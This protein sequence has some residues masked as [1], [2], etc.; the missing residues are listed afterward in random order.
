MF[1]GCST[2]QT[3]TDLPATTL[4]ESCY[5]NMFGGCSDMVVYLS[6]QSVYTKEW[7]IPKEGTGTT[8][9]NALRFM[10]VDAAGDLIT[11][12][13]INTTYYI[14]SQPYD[15]SYAIGDEEIEL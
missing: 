9:T 1:N 7:R 11:T 6:P 13:S 14:N 2:L 3:P 5:E 12:P 15:E 10:I 4:T 8:A